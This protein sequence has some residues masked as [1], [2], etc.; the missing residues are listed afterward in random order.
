MDESNS[1]KPPRDGQTIRSAL[2]SIRSGREPDRT[3][4]PAADG[5]RADEQYNIA[6]FH[7]QEIGRSFQRALSKAGVMS[8]SVIRR[9]KLEVYID[10]EDGQRAGAILDE[11]RTRFPDKPLKGLRRR[12]DYL[13]FGVLI[14]VTVGIFFLLNARQSRL[15]YSAP[16]AFGLAG[17]LSGHLIDRL[18]GH[19]RRTGRLQFGIYEFLVLAMLPG[20]V[21]FLTYIMPR[22]IHN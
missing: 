16:V 7:D 12:F 9:G 2:D 13:I 15:I 6:T 19:Y 10:F 5:M 21:A 3:P 17:G 4:G 22:L 8:D 1:G 14:G 18:R 20:I 11:H